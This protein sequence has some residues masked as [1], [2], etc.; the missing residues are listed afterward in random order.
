MTFDEL[1]EY[2]RNGMK[3]QHVYQPV[4]IRALAKSGGS[5]SYRHLAIE[6]ASL[7]E[8]SIAFYENRI[9]QMPFPVLRKHGVVEGDRQSMHLT[10]NRLT[11]EQLSVL[12]LACEERLA[13]FIA[14]RGIEVWRGLLE[15]DPV[16]ESIRYDV[17]K[18]DRRCRLCG[19]GPDDAQLQVDHIVP[20]SKGGSNEMSNLQVLC[21]IC[22][23]GKS[24][25]DD[26]D[27]RNIE[28]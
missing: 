16:P 22:N 13:G 27:L 26:T 6:L 11:D 12:V 25:R 9:R 23:R 21:A 28:D 14:E 24:N 10:V 19:A 7:D 20:R 4:L 17:L 18:R 2:V 5:A 8:S 1:L 3:M 15:F